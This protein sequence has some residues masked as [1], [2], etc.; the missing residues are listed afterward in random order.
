MKK[1]E[2]KWLSTE[3]G[4]F[5]YAISGQGEPVLVLINGAGGPIEAWHKIFHE[6]A[7]ES[8]VFAYNR[9]GIG[10]SSKPN[11]PQD[12]QTIV[13]SIRQLLL[14]VK[15]QPPYILVGHSLGGLYANLYVRQHPDEI[16]GVILLESSHP[17]DVQIQQMQGPVIRS[18]NRVLG[19]FDAFFPYRKWDET[20]YVNRTIDQIAQSGPFPDVP[21]Y[22]ITGSRKPP[23][24]PKH[25]FEIRRKHQ[26]NLARLN[27]QGKHI[28]ALRS[29]HFPQL[30]DPDIVL[31]TIRQCLQSVRKSTS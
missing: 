11:T 18:I 10:K 9:A 1:L 27:S 26:Y 8:T 2:K 5:E 20:N 21:L 4:T 30:T 6:A 14:H 29:G 25:I 13:A 16:A 28:F 31:K 19:V 12:G 7:K 23:M 24:T 3:R 15:L 22:V 17:D